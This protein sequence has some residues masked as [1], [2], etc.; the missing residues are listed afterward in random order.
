VQP[1][2]T[3]TVK[4]S[5]GGRE[6][7]RTLVVRK[8]PNSIGSE[9]DIANQLALL[10]ETRA[11]LNAVAGMIND[12]EIMRRQIADLLE[13]LPSE[14]SSLPIR[15]AAADLEKRLIAFEA[16][17]HQMRYTGS[18]Q[19]TTRWPNMTLEKLMHFAGD[20]AIGDFPPTDQQREVHRMYTDRIAGQRSELAQ[21]VRTNVAGFNQ[22]LRD[23]GI[24]AI[25]VRR[26]G[27]D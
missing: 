4:L 18:G 11:N 16:N 14:A 5:V 19:D 26:T 13:V 21:I 2:G 27:T 17:L 20:L 8:D 9:A 24:G 10:E 23:K 6:Q 12:V 1:P 22:L 3:Y 7:A 15:D 25:M